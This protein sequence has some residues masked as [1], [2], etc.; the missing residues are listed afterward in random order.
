MSVLRPVAKEHNMETARVAGKSVAMT[1]L[2]LLAKPELL[3]AAKAA[4]EED[5]RVMWTAADAS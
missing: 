5:D 3:V 4:Y 2:D 1:C